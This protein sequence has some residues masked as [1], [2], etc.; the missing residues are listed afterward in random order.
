[1]NMG[2]LISTVACL[3]LLLATGYAARKLGI[4]NDSFSKGLST[5]IV[6]IGQ[7]ALIINSLVRTKYSTEGLREGMIITVI[8]FALHAFMALYAYLACRPIRD[9][10]ERKLSEF[11]LVFTNC[12]FIG[13]PILEA[14]MGEKGLFW[15][16]FFLISLH[17]LLWT[18]GIMILAR[19]R[20]DIRPRL[21]NIILNFGT[22]PVAIGL[23]LYLARVPIPDF[24]LSFTGY[25]GSLCTPISMLITGALLATLPLKKLFCSCQLYL[26]V[27]QKLFV[28]PLLVC[29]IMTL[30]GIPDDYTLFATVIAGL[31]TAA[32]VTVFGELY[33]IKPAY[34]AL[35]IGMTSLFSVLSLPVVVSAAEW[36]MRAI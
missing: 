10:D 15:G 12:G 7:P 28:L 17:T 5:L 33:N 34:G 36:I 11:A 25:L 22:L 9:P 24:C 6:K 23:G 2:A 35:T 30:C 26:V 29:V 3:F 14:M 13:F 21:K 18:W 19:E 8:G 27:A 4:I 20:E 16:A 31:P 1:M 32:M